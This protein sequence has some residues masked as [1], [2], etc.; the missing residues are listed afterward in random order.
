M[1][2][3]VC[4]QILLFRQSINCFK[5]LGPWNMWSLQGLIG[6]WDN[7]VQPSSSREKAESKKQNLPTPQFSMSG[8]PSKGQPGLDR[9]HLSAERGFTDSI[10]LATFKELRSREPGYITWSKWGSPS[11]SSFPGAVRHRWGVLWSQRAHGLA[12]WLSQTH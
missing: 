11:L 6:R 9:N 7:P 4:F 1:L 12:S 3:H 2:I 8:C 10:L 5:H